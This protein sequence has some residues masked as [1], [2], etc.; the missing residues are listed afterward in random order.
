[1]FFSTNLLME[2][3]KEREETFNK[4]YIQRTQ[5]RDCYDWTRMYLLQIRVIFR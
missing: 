4:K 5:G 2:N 3:V 1:M